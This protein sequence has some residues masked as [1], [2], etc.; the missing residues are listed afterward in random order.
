MKFRFGRRVLR[1]IFG[2]LRPSSHGRIQRAKD[3]S[4]DESIFA[5]ITYADTQ[6]RLTGDEIQEPSGSNFEQLQ[7]LRMLCESSKRWK[8]EYFGM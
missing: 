8:T 4:V 1:P 2:R 3:D 6:E 5:R 7:A